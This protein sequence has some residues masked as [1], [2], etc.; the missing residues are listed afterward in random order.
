M[1]VHMVYKLFLTELTLNRFPRWVDTR[2]GG[3]KEEKCYERENNSTNQTLGVEDHDCYEKIAETQPMFETLHTWL[4]GCLV[5]FT[6][7]RSYT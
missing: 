6:G 3:I 2:Q 7:K 1:C 5:P 4:D